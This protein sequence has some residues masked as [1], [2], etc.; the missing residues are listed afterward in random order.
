L[1]I[2][3]RQ[4][5]SPWPDIPYRTPRLH[6]GLRSREGEVIIFKPVALCPKSP[7]TLVSPG[8]KQL[9][10]VTDNLTTF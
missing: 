10:M 8:K 2:S 4:V 3:L 6:P 1:S 5:F 9:A 7:G